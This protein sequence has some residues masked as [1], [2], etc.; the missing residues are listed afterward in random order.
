MVR[1]CS[2]TTASFTSCSRT[3]ELSLKGQESPTT[4]ELDQ[5]G[6]HLLAGKLNEPKGVLLGEVEPD[7]RACKLAEHKG[8]EVGQALWLEARH[9]CHRAVRL[10]ELL[11]RW[12]SESVGQWGPAHASH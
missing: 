8:L 3:G 11:S 4:H 12:G 9:H 2:L 10:L 6:T 7:A 1:S 5:E